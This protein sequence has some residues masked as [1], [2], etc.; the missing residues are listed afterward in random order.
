M[1]SSFRSFILLKKF[2]F[3]CMISDPILCGENRDGAV[4]TATGY[5]LEDGGVG[6]RV[7]VGARFFSSPCR[8]DRFWGQ[9]NPP[10]QWVPSALSAG[11]K[12]P[13]READHSPPTSAEVKNTWIYTPT[14]PCVFMA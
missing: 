8:P 2:K 7:P 9:P 11:V 12:R 1:Q 10:I 3:F 13:G 5:T 6:V 4:G 14:P